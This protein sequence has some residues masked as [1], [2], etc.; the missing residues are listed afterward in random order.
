M[1][2][3]H[4]YKV[5]VNRRK[6]DM[7]ALLNTPS[8]DMRIAIV[9]SAIKRGDSV[10]LDSVLNRG[11]L[12][13][14][15]QCYRWGVLPLHL[16]AQCG[17]KEAIKV[18][19]KHGY[20]RHYD[21]GHHYRYALAVAAQ[22]NNKGALE[23]WIENVDPEH[24]NAIH[25]HHIRL[26][27]DLQKAMRTVVREGNMEMIRFIEERYPQDIRR[28]YA[29]LEAVTVAI[30]YGLPN[31]VR[32]FLEL[33]GYDFNMRTPSFF[34]GLLM[35]A[36]LDCKADTRPEIVR[37]LLEHGVDPNRTFSEGLHRV[38]G[39]PL[40]R[41]ILKG[42]VETMSLLVEYGAD[43]NATSVGRDG[44]WN[45]VCS[46]PPLI[47]AMRQRSAD[48]VRVLLEK[49]ANRTCLSRWQ[50]ILVK[51]GEEKMTKKE[52]VIWKGKDQEKSY[53][54]IVVEQRPRKG[55][56]KKLDI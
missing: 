55:K 42:D 31:I 2:F 51:T 17:G 18:L 48:M 44:R 46:P 37:L 40:Q 15:K 19:I 25:L 47:H 28:E 9:C 33:G 21:L 29:R 13:L 35:T 52:I 43:V 36:I 50:T 8:E 1:L 54:F 45:T 34:K 16:A 39:T 41:A 20:P 4:R 56:G 22:N 3:A 6:E 24:T 53:S 23:A 32:H 5:W 26:S 27:N 10:E 12:P 38:T 7:L 11:R 14:H 49:A 30:Q